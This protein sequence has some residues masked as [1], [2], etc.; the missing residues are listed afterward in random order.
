MLPTVERVTLFSVGA[1]VTVV[2]GAGVGVAAGGG[3]R[4]GADAGVRTAATGVVVFDAEDAAGAGGA[5]DTN[6]ADG[7]R[8][9]AAGDESDAACEAGMRADATCVIDA[10]RSGVGFAFFR[11]SRALDS[12]GL[13]GYSEISH[14]SRRDADSRS[15]FDP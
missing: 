7:V 15:S 6:D 11:R 8:G 9:A 4:D 12:S 5:G 3:A 14:T 1:G 13:C 2:A 10:G